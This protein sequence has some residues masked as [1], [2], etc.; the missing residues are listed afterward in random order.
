MTPLGHPEERKRRGVSIK[1]RR[2]KSPSPTPPKKNFC[3]FGG[4]GG[5]PSL[6]PGRPKYGRLGRVSPSHYVS[7][8]ADFAKGLLFKSRRLN[9]APS[10][11]PQE[12]IKRGD[13]SL[14]S[15]W[16]C[17]GVTPNVVSGLIFK[18]RREKSTPPSLPKQNGG[19]IGLDW[20]YNVNIF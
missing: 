3:R 19:K 8:R 12:N 9:I 4:N 13:F 16:P 14:R 11:L 15:K 20:G 17:R 5:D 2:E 10:R 7:P 1:W 6:H 18:S